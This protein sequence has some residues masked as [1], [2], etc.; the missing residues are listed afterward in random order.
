[1]YWTCARTQPNREGIAESELGR[2]GFEVYSPRIAE[3]TVRRGAK[4]VVI[5]S[6]FANYLFIQIEA[7]F[8]SAMNCP[9]V[10][11]LLLDGERP[12]KVP[13]TV[14]TDLRSRERNGLVVLPREPR[15]KPGDPVRVT[16]G[17]LIGLRGLYQGQKPR[18]RISVLLSVLGRVEI[19]AGD[20][21]AV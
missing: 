6:L 13:L 19:A 4:I 12:A 20:V 21:E 18:E 17:V 16:R 15:F 10:V 8:Y 3:R 9:G 7:Q 1:M 14:I 2:R 5:K 11:T